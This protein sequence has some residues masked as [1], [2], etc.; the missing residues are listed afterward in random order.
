MRKVTFAVGAAL[1]FTAAMVFA[2]ARARAEDLRGEIR[3]KALACCN[4]T[5]GNQTCSACGELFITC[6]CSPVDGHAECY[7]SDGS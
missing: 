5:C 1:L 6:H 2:P 7:G 4:V 3:A